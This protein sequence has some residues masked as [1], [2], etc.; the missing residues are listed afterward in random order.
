MSAPFVAG[1][2]ALLLSYDASLDVFDVADL[3]G[4]TARSL[5]LINQLQRPLLGAGKIDVSASLVALAEGDIPDGPEL[6]DDDCFD[7][8]A[9]QALADITCQGFL[10]PVT[11]VNLQ[12]PQGASCTLDGTQ[13]KGNIKVGNDAS[14]TA[15]R[16]TVI[17]NIQAEGARLVEVLADSTVGGSIQ[18]KRGG[19]GRVENVSVNRDIQF[20][21]NNGVLSAAGNQVGGNIQVYQNVGGSTIATNIV[22]G[23][24]QCKENN[25][26][27]DGGNNTV[28]GNKEDQCATL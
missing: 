28:Q 22:N 20:E 3:L 6:L 1:Q 26:S 15:Y 11:V 9:T 17:G 27:P 5:D 16:I 23:N 7:D 12:V 19:S 21:S 24:L 10:G 2:A 14:L 4:G 13:V 18:L 8:P 25:P